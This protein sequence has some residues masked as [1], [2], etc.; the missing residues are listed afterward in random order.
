MVVS[1][2][3]KNCQ[4]WKLEQGPKLTF[5]GRR[6]VAT[7]FFFFSRHMEKCGRQKVEKKVLIKFCFEAKRKPKFWVARC[8]LYTFSCLYL[9]EKKFTRLKN[10]RLVLCSMFK[11]VNDLSFRV[12][13]R[14][15]T[16]R[17]VARTRPQPCSI[18]RSQNMAAKLRTARAVKRCDRFVITGKSVLYFKSSG[19]VKSK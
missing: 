17:H 14:R 12:L 5:L 9:V 3:P 4:I 1:V 15:S 18:S 10:C 16:D 8:Q 2:T 19:K 13:S 6:Q 7:D 11:T